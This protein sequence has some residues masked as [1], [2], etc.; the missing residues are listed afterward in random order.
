MTAYYTRS[1]DVFTPTDYATG[2]WDP[3]LCHA[4]PPAALLLDAAASAFEGMGLSR[5]TF[6]IPSGIPKVPVTIR[7]TELRPGRKVRLVRL[8]LVAPDDDELM[9]ANVWGIRILDGSVPTSDPYTRA[10]P[11]PDDCEPLHLRFGEG[12]GYMDGVEMRTI[13]GTPFAGGSAIIWIRRTIPLV[14][15]QESDPYSLLGL[16]GDLGNGI[17]AMEPLERLMAINTDVTIYASRR[18]EGPW[19]GMES[20]TISHGMGL[21]ITDSLLYDAAGFV[22]KANQSIFIDRP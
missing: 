8:A 19:I 4:G 10:L 22:G 17:S 7:L 18:P 1:G 3:D 2:P 6:E 15:G 12:L 21:G 14:E 13:E 5:A 16:F 9:T 11:D 20:S